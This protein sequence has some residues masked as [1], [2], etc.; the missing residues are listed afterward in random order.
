MIAVPVLCA[1]VY[2]WETT[3]HPTEFSVKS[4]PER[5]DLGLR[6]ELLFLLPINP[7]PLKCSRSSYGFWAT[8]IHI[9]ID[10]ASQFVQLSWVAILMR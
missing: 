8:V 3:K 2:A 9:L 6:P 10:S 4:V 7:F 5:D 1:E